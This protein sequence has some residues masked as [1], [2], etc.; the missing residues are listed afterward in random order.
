MANIFD[1]LT[2]VQYDSFYDIPL[3][4]LDILALTELTYLSFDNLLDESDNR[5]LDVA[6]RVPRESNMLTNKERLQL[7]DQ[8]STHKRFKN[9]KLSNFVNDID[10]EL[11]KQFAA[12]TYR[13]NLDTYLIVFRGT[14][15]SIIGW[16]EDFHMTYMKEIPAQKH[17]LEYLEDFFKQYP[18]QKVIIAGHSKGGNL[19]VYAASQIQPELQEKISA[20]FTYDAPGLQAH[21]TETS[22]YQEVIPKI[23]RYVPQGS[24]IG[25]MLEIPDTPIVVRSLALGGI[26]QHNTFSWQTEGTHLVQLEEISSESLQIKD[27]LKEWMDSVPDEELELYFNLFFGTILESGI[28]SINDLS[29]TGA[30]EHIHQLVSQAQT[31]EPQQVEIL[32]NLTQLLLDARFQ[33]WKNHF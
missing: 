7:L 22:G 25:M 28:N 21:L 31:L 3:N 24:V 32:R 29:S 18:K 8:L 6:T 14:D 4:E 1:Y 19:A 26:A 33:A 5:L 9:S 17:A 23:H 27:A 15:D 12:M 20:V 2:D 11:Q 10:V 13:L 30:I 16:K